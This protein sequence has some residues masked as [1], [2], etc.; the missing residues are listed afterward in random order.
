MRILVHTPASLTYGSDEWIWWDQLGDCRTEL[1]SDHLARNDLEV[2]SDPALADPGF[3]ALFSCQTVMGPGM[4][5]D[6]PDPLRL[7]SGTPQTCPTT[8]EQIQAGGAH[9]CDGVLGILHREGLEGRAWL[10]LTGAIVHQ[11][12][13][14][15][16]EP[17]G[18]DVGVFQYQPSTA[19]TLPA[20]GPTGGPVAGPP[21]G[22]AAGGGAGG[23]AERPVPLARE[24]CNANRAVVSEA[25]DGA[26]LH[27]LLGVLSGE[28]VLLLSSD[29]FFR[30]SHR[31]DYLTRIRDLPD[32]VEGTLTVRNILPDVRGR[33]EVANLAPQWK[34]AVRSLLQDCENDYEVEFYRTPGAGTRTKA[35]RSARDLA[36]IPGR[37]AAVNAAVVRAVVGAGRAY[38]CLG[39]GLFLMSEDRNF[40][41]HGGHLDLVREDP[42]VLSG[43]LVIHRTSRTIVV[44]GRLADDR[45]RA[46]TAAVRDFCG[47]EVRFADEQPGSGRLPRSEFAEFFVSTQRDGAWWEL[48]NADALKEDNR[49]ALRNSRPA[50]DSHD[51]V[52]L[53]DPE[54]NS[55]ELKFLF[56]RNVLFL[57]SRK[58]F[59]NHREMNRQYAR[60][61][62]KGD[63]RI[64]GLL[65][66]YPPGAR[67][68]GGWKLQV[69]P[70]VTLS[71]EQ[72][73]RIRLALHD[74]VPHEVEFFT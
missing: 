58:D 30:H 72:E 23:G 57:S 51:P 44:E 48:Y 3:P 15:P 34:R 37:A 67:T 22:P 63:E 13:A 2:W 6:V 16:S 28:T 36:G 1:N 20:E 64:T 18:T 52:S 43:C 5:A 7:C 66:V 39:G 54:G 73:H 35:E 32:T 56:T 17:N 41:D 24:I 60:N 59:G 65:L 69:V 29:R 53:D 61:A 19:P 62:K 71:G 74:L 4:R 68:G 10:I 42:K 45:K 31:G 55:R 11:P 38:Y 47:H 25:R 70:D 46:I 14:G 50:S 27:F 21:T 12:E 9:T 8:Q 40:L 49:S 26:K 33:F